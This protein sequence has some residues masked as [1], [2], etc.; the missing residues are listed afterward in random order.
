MKNLGIFMDKH[1]IANIKFKELLLPTL[2]IA[3]A[4]NISAVIDSFFVAFADELRRVHVQEARN[5][6]HCKEA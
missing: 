6:C 4:L 3:M 1:F 2:L 5:D